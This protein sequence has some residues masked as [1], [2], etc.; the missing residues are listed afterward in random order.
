LEADASLMEV[1]EGIHDPRAARGKRHPLPALL[2]LAVVGMLAG[3]TGYEAIV[4]YGKQRGGEFLRLLG[5][6]RR[7]GLCKATYSRVFRRI[8]V[9]DFESRVGRWIRGQLGPHDA[10]HLAIDGKTAR[11]SRDGQAPGIHPVSAY[12]PDVKA[13]LDQLRVDAKTNEH[14]AALGLLGVLPIE[15]RIITGDAMFT[16]RDVCASVIERGGD[17]ILPVKENQPTLRADIAA[18]FAQPGAELSPPAGGAG[19]GRGR[20]VLRS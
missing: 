10:A 3:M 1:L 7:R 11:G 19:R 17:Y 13:V 18:A 16:H 5:F 2:A 8:D 9:A 14:K 12:A 20:P 4:D 15:G 6:T